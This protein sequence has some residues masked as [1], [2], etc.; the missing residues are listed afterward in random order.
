MEINLNV[1]KINDDI[2]IRIL[3]LI[4]FIILPIININYLI[5]SIVAKNGH[6]FTTKLDKAIRFNSI[7]IIPYVYWYIYIIV[8]F[9]FI[10]ISSRE[11][12]MR[13]F[14]SFF[15][16]MCI[17][18]IVYYL[19]PTEISR[20]IIPD[21][22]I[23]NSLVRLIYSADRPV[24]CFPSLHVLT[25]YFLM[26]YTKYEKSKK[27]FYY[28]QITG[29]LIIVS[30]VFVKQHFVVDILGA[31]ILAEIVIFFVKKIDDENINKILDLPYKF[32]DKIIVKFLDINSKVKK[33]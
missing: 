7:F 1:I 14:L 27:K 11:K 13:I 32:K 6:D 17:C 28:T 4:W 8:G 10:L 21:N 30:T 3:D 25:T 12:Y 29:G 9:I 23:F 5:A 20:P 15:I 24:N 31:I 33:L 16:G 19:Y 18:Y 2:E 26:R 22:N